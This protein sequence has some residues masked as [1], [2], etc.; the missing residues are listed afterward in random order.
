MNAA[1]RTTIRRA[2]DGLRLAA[3]RL[4]SARS[5]GGARTDPAAAAAELRVELVDGFQSIAMALD[6]ITLD[7]EE[8]G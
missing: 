5:G 6:V 7:L 3:H 8:D 2:A 1:Q 4:A